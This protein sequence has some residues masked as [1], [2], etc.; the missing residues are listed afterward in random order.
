V[1]VR[2]ESGVEA[3]ERLSSSVSEGARGAAACYYRRRWWV[4]LEKE[5]D[6]WAGS[7]SKDGVD[8]C[9]GRPGNANEFKN[10]S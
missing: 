6:G 1:P 10:N 5:E 7:G 3:T 2:C 9:V 8:H 4:H